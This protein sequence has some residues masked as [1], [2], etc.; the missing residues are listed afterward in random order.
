MV[1]LLIAG[2]IMSLTLIF[3]R[4]AR[5][6]TNTEVNLGRQEE[7]SER[8]SPNPFS[9]NVVRMFITFGNTVDKIIPERIKGFISSRLAPPD[10]EE[11]KQSESREYHLTL[12]EPLLI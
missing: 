5:T 12:L 10:E 2:I 8:F 3:S 11:I 7:G 1:F 4:K 6:V 9:R